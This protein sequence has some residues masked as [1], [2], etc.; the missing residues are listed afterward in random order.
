VLLGGQI[1]DA[2]AVHRGVGRTQA[3]AEVA[4]ALLRVLAF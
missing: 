4:E 1:P 3:L 2:R